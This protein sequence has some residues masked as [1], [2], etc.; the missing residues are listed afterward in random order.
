MQSRVLLRAAVLG[1]ASSLLA[2][3]LAIADTVGADTDTLT[4]GNQGSIDLGSVAPGSSRTVAV[5]FTLTC[6]GSSHLDAGQVVTL[7]YAGAT[8]PA[9]GSVQTTGTTI[10]RPDGWPGDGYECATPAQTASTPTPATITVTAPAAVGGPYSYEVLF[11]ATSSPNLAGISR[12]LGVTLT[13][14]VGANTPPT[15]DLPDDVTVVTA[16]SAG[17]FVDF[18]ASAT[19]AEDGPDPAVECT[20]AAGSW[21]PVGA[22]TVS[23][24]ATDLGG[25]TTTGT[26]EVT[27]RYEAPVTVWFET[28]VR[29]S[30][31]TRAP[32][33]RTLPVKVHLLRGGV[34]IS[35][36]DVDLIVAICDGGSRTGPPI[37]MLP[38]GPR[39]MASV[40]LGGT[41][42]CTRVDVRLDGRVVG[43]F[44]VVSDPPGIARGATSPR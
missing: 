31:P 16:D 9:G 27:V 40:A 17:S 20:P 14:T 10:S 43:G 23:C 29:A 2:A 32:T 6:S 13:L 8:T 44:D 12:F 22:T 42:A 37:P 25:L 39:W 5:S 24:S 34:A 4:P 26:F 36:A 28:P 18:S 15:L 33:N 11:G 1:L 35:D 21:F 19:D 38:T 41:S 30:G 7:A 3:G